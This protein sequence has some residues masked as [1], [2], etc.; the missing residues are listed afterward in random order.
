A[1]T[2]PRSPAGA[3]IGLACGDVGAVARRPE[4]ARLTGAVARGVAAH[5][6]GAKGGCA[7]P[8]IA[9]GRAERLGRRA[10]TCSAIVARTAL[11][12]IGARRTDG[13]ARPGVAEAAH[14]IA[15][16]RALLRIDTAGAAAR[17]AAV[18]V[19]L[20]LVPHA[21]G[22]GRGSAREPGGITDPAQTVG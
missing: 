17:A 18:G 4:I 19:R 6:V 10:D 21:V 20:V 2:K 15:A 1:I 13:R 7:L 22:A 3:G 14:T 5:A 9:T 8:V 12:V 11:R 16:A